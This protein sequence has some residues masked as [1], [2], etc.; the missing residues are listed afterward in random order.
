M[1]RYSREAA[2]MF[3]PEEKAAEMN[4]IRAEAFSAGAMGW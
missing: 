3:W 2:D 1:S 4:A